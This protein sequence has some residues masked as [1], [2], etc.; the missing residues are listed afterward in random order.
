MLNHWPEYA[1]EAALLGSFMLSACTLGVLLWHPRSMFARV[2]DGV[3]RRALMG[4]AMGLTAIALI[5]SPWGQQSGA[6]MNPA[7]TLTFFLRGK[8]APWDAVFYAAAQFVGGTAGVALARLVLRDWLRHQAVDHVVTRPGRRGVAVA[9]VAELAIAFGMMFTVLYA[10]NDAALTAYTGLFAGALVAL[11]ITFE[12]PL[13]GMS[14]NPARSFASSIVA[15]RWSA[16][17]VYMTAPVAG[18]LLASAAYAAL[19]EHDRVY[20]AKLDHCNNHRCIFN[21]EFDQLEAR[22]RPAHAETTGP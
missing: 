14:L 3:A 21:C 9:W 6:H 1:M 20:C 7:T 22:R 12:A 17:W 19:P 8:V 18:M 4:V 5:Y 11:Y 13:S 15:R 10:S 2:P 16:Y